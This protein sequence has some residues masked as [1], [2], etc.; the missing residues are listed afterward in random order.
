MLGTEHYR[1]NLKY[2]TGTESPLPPTL[3]EMGE[4]SAKEIPLHMRWIRLDGE[5]GGLSTFVLVLNLAQLF[6]LRPAA[7]M[8]TT[9]T[10]GSKPKHLDPSELGTKE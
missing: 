4:D 2:D 3:F 1:Y 5:G 6:A 10:P 9:A 8:T 7:I